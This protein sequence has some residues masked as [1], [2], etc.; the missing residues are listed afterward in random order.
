MQTR[1]D[2][3]YNFEITDSFTWNLILQD[4]QLVRIIFFVCLLLR[5]NSI[6]SMVS[7][8]RWLKRQIDSEREPHGFGSKPNRVNL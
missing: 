6:L 8:P 3:D 1:F 7:R 2:A 5:S 4:S